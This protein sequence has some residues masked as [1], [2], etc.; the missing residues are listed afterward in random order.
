[1]VADIEYA[2]M[3]GRAYASKTENKANLP[4]VPSGWTEESPKDLGNGLNI[5]SF[6]RGN[7]IVISISGLS[8]PG[9]VIDW[10]N[11]VSTELGYG[12]P[13]MLDAALYY[14]QIKRDYPDADISFTGHSMGGGFAALLGVLFDESA[15]TFDQAPF[16][17]SA[18]EGVKGLVS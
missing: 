6:K 10:I 15:V 12:S 11:G 18:W 9:D 3:A 17:R 14:M 1:M 4:P 7:E 2:L 5:T 13:Q 8:S 16:S